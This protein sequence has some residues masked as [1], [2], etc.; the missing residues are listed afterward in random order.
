MQNFRFILKKN[1]IFFIRN[2]AQISQEI[3]QEIAE[4]LRNPIKN[5]HHLNKNFKSQSFILY[6]TAATGFDFNST[7]FW[8]SY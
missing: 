6:E 1:S 8:N 5:V 2:I 4:L 7:M 3:L